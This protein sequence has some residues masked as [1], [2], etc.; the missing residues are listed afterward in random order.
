[1]NLFWSTR[2]LTASRED[3]LT[4]FFAAALDSS[5]AFRE[6]YCKFVLG[7]YAERKHWGPILIVDVETQVNFAGTT[8]QPDMLLKLSNGKHIV[9]EHKLDALE[10]QGPESDPRG[11]LLRYLDLPVDGL[12]YTRSLWKPPD[13]VVLEHPKYI[14]PRN[15]EHFLWRDFYPLL[16][17]NSDLIPQWLCDGFERLGFTPPH[18]SIG[19]MSGKDID[20]NRRNREN[21]AK[22]W[23]PT[24]IR[25]RKLGWKVH[26]DSIVELYLRDNMSSI[27]DWVFISPSKSDR[28]L[29]RATPHPGE[30]ERVKVALLQATMLLPVPTEVVQN[31]VPRKEGKVQVVDVTTSLFEILGRNKLTVTEIETRLLA[32]V[33][34]LLEALQRN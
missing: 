28:F 8:C 18:P 31:E 33:S 15:R 1:M 4:E 27:A 19:E 10:T 24:R 6:S 5:Q 3:H 17:G 12:M 11:Q 22:L 26:A 21:F 9:C 2:S 13:S 34:P 20:L 23:N 14:R 25:A 32:F 30:L 7:R 16:K 29:V